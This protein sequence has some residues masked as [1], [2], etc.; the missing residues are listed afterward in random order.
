MVDT[1]LK[2]DTPGSAVSS[3]IRK[4]P[5]LDEKV[6]ISQEAT[7]DVAIEIDSRPKAAAEASLLAGLRRLENNQFML[8]A[9]ALPEDQNARGRPLRKI[10]LKRSN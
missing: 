1:E 4:T 3:V 10:R 7:N 5:G 6:V 8:P 9:A 2:N